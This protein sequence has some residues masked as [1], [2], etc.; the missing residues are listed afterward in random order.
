MNYCTKCESFYSQP[1]TCNCY[2]PPPVTITTVGVPDVRQ[3]P[4]CRRYGCHET[5][6]ICN[7][8]PEYGVTIVF[9]DPVVS[10]DIAGKMAEVIQ[11]HERL[12]KAF[13]Q[14]GTVT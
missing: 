4:V 8:M 12:D 14:S 3:C 13:S 6:V 1:G 11:R 10:T 2:A 7:P 5:H 9:G